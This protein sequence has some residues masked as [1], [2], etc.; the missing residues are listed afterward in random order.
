MMKR[1]A[2]DDF[3]VSLTDL[4][5]SNELQEMQDSF[6]EVANVSLRTVDP[7]GKLITRISNAASLCSDA[8]QGNTAKESLC[9]DCLPSFLGGRGIVD[10][11]LSFECLPG[12]TSYLVPLKVCFSET[13]S[14]IVGYMVVG[15]IIFIK[16]KSR[17]EFDAVAAEFGLDPYQLWSFVLELRVFSYQGIHSLLD[18]IENLTNR[19]LALAHGKFM[20]H[21]KMKGEL[22]SR[23]GARESLSSFSGD[24]FLR[25]FLDLV[26]EM[27]NGSVGSVMLLDEKKKEL[28]ICAARG[29]PQ[30]VV[31]TSVLKLGEG[32][33]GLAAQTKKSFL[34]NQD[35]ADEIISDRLK[36]P[37]LFSSL[38]VP[39]KCHDAVYGVVNVSSDASNPVRFDKSSLSFVTKA[40]G[41]AGVA[42]SRLRN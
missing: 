33:A 11:D 37:H 16:R 35:A 34:I 13:S 17:E 40:A 5:G 24:E 30:D 39:I 38:I 21:R 12:L 8:L 27:T 9:S 22:A 20:M 32:I 18:M 14:L 15:P 7:K 28:S 29:L 26:I 41:L 6:A 23:I 42:L 10:E 3:K 31:R 2:E 36:R 4:I 1:F 19:I 25:L